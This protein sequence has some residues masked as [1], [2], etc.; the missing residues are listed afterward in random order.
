MPPR[1]SC[2]SFLPHPAPRDR[3]GFNATTA[4]LLRRPPGQAWVVRF[5]F[6]CHHGVPASTRMPLTPSP[7][8][9]V[10]MP[11]RRSCFPPA[12]PAGSPSRPTFQC[13]HG[14][15]ASRPCGRGWGGIGGFNATTAFLL[16][17]IAPTG[18]GKTRVFQC[19]HGVPASLLKECR[20]TTSC[21][22]SMPPRRSCFKPQEAGNDPRGVVSMPPRRSCFAA[23][24]WHPV[25]NLREFQCHHGVPASTRTSCG[26]LDSAAVSMP[27]R[28]SCFLDKAPERV[29]ALLR[30]NA[31]TAFLLRYFPPPW[32]VPAPRFNATTAF[33]LRRS[34]ERR[35]NPN[36]RFNATTAFLLLCRR[37][38]YRWRKGLFQ[39]HHGVPAS[40]SCI[41]F[42]IKKAA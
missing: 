20:S 14:V 12:S 26:S 28:R 39:C 7:T 13:H 8:S 19:H 35:C 21:K 1:R 15:P 4:F 16:L 25:P 36:S 10:S 31:T 37:H 5:E 34:G 41:R 30:F 33:L 11:P 40:T 32:G 18:A 22:V 38:A 24:V 2:F 23:L 17:V 3:G 6:Q 42:Q 27:P 29:D 9:P